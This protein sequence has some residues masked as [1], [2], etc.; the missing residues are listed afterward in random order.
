MVVCNHHTGHIRNGR[1]DRI[2][3]LVSTGVPRQILQHL[4]N[5]NDYFRRTLSNTA[6]D[7]AA[8]R[9]REAVCS[10]VARFYISLGP[11]QF[12][13]GLA[14]ADRRFRPRSSL[15][16]LLSAGLWLCLR[17]VLGILELLGSRKMALHFSHP[18][19][20]EDL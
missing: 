15:A 10:G 20:L 5:G 3:Q 1:S 16:F 7:C 6:G 18:A 13:S 8:G 4:A 9:S 14:L 17:M 12:P 11:N 19:T 2:F